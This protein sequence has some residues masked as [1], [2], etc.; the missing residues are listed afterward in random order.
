M[1]QYLQEPLPD[2]WARVTIEEVLPVCQ[3][4]VR[5]LV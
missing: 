1:S 5:H 4:E 2:G 3:P